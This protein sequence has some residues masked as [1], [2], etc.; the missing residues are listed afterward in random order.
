MSEAD[1]WRTIVE[2]TDEHHRTRLL[3]GLRG[4]RLAN[5]ARERVGERVLVSHDG[6]R[7]FMYTDTPRAP[8]RWPNRGRAA[9]RA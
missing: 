1:D 4:R 6:P 2:L 9:G 7:V 8:T 5:E 3:D